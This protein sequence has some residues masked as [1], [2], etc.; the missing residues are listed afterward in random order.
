[1][2][3]PRINLVPGM[4]AY[5]VTVKRVPWGGYS[6]S[7]AVLGLILLYPT[8][9]LSGYLVEAGCALALIGLFVL[10]SKASNVDCPGHQRALPHP[11]LRLRRQLV[12]RGMLPPDSAPAE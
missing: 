2:G 5:P 10:A 8:W 1:M 9:G 11:G 3:S 6:V 4:G 12:L 7:F